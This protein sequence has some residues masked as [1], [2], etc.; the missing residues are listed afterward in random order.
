M[1]HSKLF[2]LPS[3]QISLKKAHFVLVGNC[4]LFSGWHLFFAYYASIFELRNYY[5]KKKEQGFTAL[6]L[7]FTIIIFI[8]F[9][10]KI[11]ALVHATLHY[12]F[13]AFFAYSDANFDCK[14]SWQTVEEELQYNN[15]SGRNQFENE[16]IFWSH[17]LTT[18]FA[19]NCST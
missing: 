13:E 9:N 10:C 14:A 16:H 5:A 4:V 1:F 15:A 17:I 7:L 8:F 6:A 11:R 18:Y 12:W 3:R 19:H 2:H